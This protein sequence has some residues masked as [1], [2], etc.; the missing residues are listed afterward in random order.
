M[1]F[2]YEDLDRIER[3]GYALGF[4]AGYS[5]FSEAVTGFL[6]L[7]EKDESTVI[8]RLRESRAFKEFQAR[9]FALFYTGCDLI[10]EV[11]RQ[12]VVDSYHLHEELELKEIH[13]KLDIKE[14]EAS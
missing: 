7:F 10:E 12:D 11:S 2:E 6:G 13:E 8:G 3:K 4:V 9:R 1:S 14:E 5:L